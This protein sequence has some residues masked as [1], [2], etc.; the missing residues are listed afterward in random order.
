MDIWQLLAFKFVVTKKWR[1]GFS[2]EGCT[3][4]DAGNLQNKEALALSQR[5]GTPTLNIRDVYIER[6][7][8]LL[9]LGM[10]SLREE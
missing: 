4:V 6:K 7:L 9:C 8:F 5:L 3:K 1:A 10:K 2:V